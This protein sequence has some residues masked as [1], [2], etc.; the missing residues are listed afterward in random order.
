MRILSKQHMNILFLYCAQTNV[1]RNFNP[2]S[3]AKRLSKI[4]PSD[5]ITYKK[6]LGHYLD[7]PLTHSLFITEGKGWQTI[8][9]LPIIRLQH[10][11]KMLLAGR[12]FILINIVNLRMQHNRSKIE[13]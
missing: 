8:I 2:I 1:P 4:H 11:K 7:A 3:K 12:N 13:V 10:N 9:Y 5:R 6:H